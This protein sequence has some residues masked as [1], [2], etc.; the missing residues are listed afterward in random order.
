MSFVVLDQEY[1]IACPATEDF[2]TIG[3]D[4]RAANFV[5]Y[6]KDINTGVPVKDTT[7][8]RPGRNGGTGL[9]FT[10]TA[11]RTVT[12]DINLIEVDPALRYERYS[13]IRRLLNLGR[14]YTLLLQ[15][16]DPLNNPVQ[17]EMHTVEDDQFTHDSSGPLK[18][19]GLTF[20]AWNPYI[21]TQ[22][23]TQSTVLPGE[24]FTVTNI[25]DENAFPVLYFGGGFGMARL[26]NLVTKEEVLI[27]MEV[28]LGSHLVLDSY[29]R[30]LKLNGRR[31]V[32]KAMPVGSD[33]MPEFPAG[34]SEWVYAV[35]GIH[36][37]A[38]PT[39]RLDWR[40]TWL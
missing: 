21:V 3:S 6:V 39:L 35:E 27:D 31:N 24:R 13:L 8:D 10:T 15:W 25:G 17:L 14:R 29:R 18:T 2:F 5:G 36:P 16:T 22:S 38:E 30:T 33:Y 19:V 34:T 9:S 40:H 32:Y 26:Q 20:K 12:I 11:S 1:T 23:I 37:A 28:N 7:V 4:S